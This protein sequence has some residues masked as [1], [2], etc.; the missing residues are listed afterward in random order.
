M[1]E[2]IRAKLE[3]AGVNVNEGVERFM[4]KE[5]LFEKFSRET[6]IWRSSRLR[7]KAV[8]KRRRSQQPTH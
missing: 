4:G 1:R 2:E 5:E 3:E 6:P 7:Q 8:I